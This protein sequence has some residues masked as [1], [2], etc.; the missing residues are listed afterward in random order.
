MAVSEKLIEV[1]EWTG[2]GYKPIVDYGAWRVA[3]L[4]WSSKEETQNIRSM[5]KHDATDEVF[6][7]LQGKCRLLLADGAAAP[8]KILAQ[9]MELRKAYN[10]KKAIWHNHCLSRDAVVLIVENVDTSAANSVTVQLGPEGLKEIRALL[11]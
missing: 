6:V 9:D 2:E 3:V 10:V 1:R 4:N 8:G 11:P 5:Q 7:L